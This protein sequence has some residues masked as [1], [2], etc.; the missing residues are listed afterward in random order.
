MFKIFLLFF[1]IF[2]SCPALSQESDC[3]Q[4]KEQRI[5]PEQDK[6]QG[7]EPPYCGDPYEPILK[8]VKN[9]I[10]LDSLD[11]YVMNRDFFNYFFLKHS[12]GEA[13]YGDLISFIEGFKSEP[14]YL[15]GRDKI[16]LRMKYEY[17]IV[18][19]N[20]WDEVKVLFEEFGLNQK[21]LSEFKEFLYKS[22]NR[23]LNYSRAYA[24]FLDKKN[25]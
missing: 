7:V 20:D 12:S 18:D 1:S 9:C 22:K 5:I 16:V 6:T 17:K 21:E 23:K 19:K 25:R 14:E 24:K 10:P 3:E 4:I 15:T 13:T 11:F 2:L 8:K